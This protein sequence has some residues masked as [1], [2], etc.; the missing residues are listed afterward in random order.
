MIQ[1]SRWTRA[2]AV[3]AALLIFLTACVERKLLIRSEPPGARVVLN[4]DD[5][6][7]APVEVPFNTYGTFDIVASHPKGRRLHTTAPV[8]PPWYE[9]IP[10][11]L[12]FEAVWPFTLHDE[13]D[14]ALTLEPI[15]AADEAA[16]G[17]REDILRERMER[18]Q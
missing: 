15:G 8:R 13:H 7:T 6:G 14:I 3:A 16:I 17:S 12:F 1:P 4:G 11:D 9:Q 5:I 2:V 10:L 18:G